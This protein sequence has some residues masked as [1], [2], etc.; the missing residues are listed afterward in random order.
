MAGVLLG[1]GFGLSVPLVNHMT[2]SRSNLSNRGRRLA[3]LSMALFSG[4]FL[5]SFM[6][7]LPGDSSI[8]FAVT[9]GF[10]ILVMVVLI[11]MR[12]TLA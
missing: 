12:K 5:A 4:Q 10:S 7:M 8:T 11:L 6:A 3:S 1:G 9:S 2:V